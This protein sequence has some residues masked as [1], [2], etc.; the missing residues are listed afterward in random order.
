M[1]SVR[2]TFD[3]A[4][5]HGRRRASENFPRSVKTR[6]ALAVSFGTGIFFQFA[7]SDEPSSASA[8]GSSSSP[9]SSLSSSRLINWRV[10][11]VRR[12]TRLVDAN[13][14]CQ[15][16]S[17]PLHRLSP[18]T[19][20]ALCDDGL[21][22]VE[23]VFPESFNESDRFFQVLEYHRML[24]PDY[25]NRWAKSKPP[26]AGHKTWPR[27][28]PAPADVPGLEMDFRFC[29]RSPN[30][31]NQDRACQDLQFRIAAY[32]VVACPGDAALQM[33]GYR[34]IK[35][36]AEHGHPDGMC[37]YGKNWFVLVCC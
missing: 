7:G 19:N 17:S 6:L 2:T 4:W 5:R 20:R 15:Y 8:S 22:E 23:T 24:L 12:G 3:Q 10:L 9:S 34:M 27:K 28:I 36:L 14:S 30:Y 1:P 32:Y 33:K 35:D 26:A 37:L 13:T 25:T 31:R 21:L 29:K 16:Y 11:A 18:T